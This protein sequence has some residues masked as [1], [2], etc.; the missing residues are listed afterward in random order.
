MNAKTSIEIKIKI[1]I[2]LEFIF[3]KNYFSITF[4]EESLRLFNSIEENT[5]DLFLNTKLMFAFSWARLQALLNFYT[6]T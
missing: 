6:V 1:Y 3:S 4:T 5:D 2:S